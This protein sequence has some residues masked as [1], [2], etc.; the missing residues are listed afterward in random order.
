MA[1]DPRTARQRYPS[2]LAPGIIRV[3][4]FVAFLVVA[5]DPLPPRI[6]VATMDETDP[7]QLAV[8]TVLQPYLPRMYPC[9]P[10]AMALYNEVPANIR[11]E[12]DDRAA[13]SSV[14]CHVWSAFQREFAEESGFHFLDVRGLHLLN[15]HDQVLIRAKKVDANGRH[16]NNDTPQQRAFDAQEDLPGLPSAAVRL[17]MGYQPDAAFSE[18]ERVTV[19]RPLGRWVSQIVEAEPEHS[20]VD[21]TPVELP[22]AAMRRRRARG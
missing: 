22:F 3:I 1:G 11:A 7:D 21:I 10:A 14:Y 12:H 16:R 5:W 13:A 8:M 18:V 17:V 6:T 2:G 19:R 4:F 9:F 20:W 15:I